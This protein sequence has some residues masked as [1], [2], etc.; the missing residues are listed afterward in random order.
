ML[1]TTY[2]PAR[3]WKGEPMDADALV[4]EYL[5]RLAEAASG[6]PPARR[7]ELTAEVQEHIDAALVEAGRS[8]EVTVRNVLDRLGSPDQIVAAESELSRGAA[9]AGPAIPSGADAVVRQ[10]AGSRWGGVEIIALLLLTVGAIVLPFVGP[11]VGLVF[12][13]ASSQW[14]RQEKLVAT[15]I[16]VLLLLPTFLIFASSVAFFTGSGVSGPQ[17]MPSEPAYP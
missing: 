12:V 2:S 1:W 10:A 11:L 14:T 9:G 17:V 16:V 7:A 3:A 13:W 6:L 8:D 4:R 15:G 5:G